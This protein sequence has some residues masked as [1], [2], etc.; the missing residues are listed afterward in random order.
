V[1]HQG[2]EWIRTSLDFLRRK[3]ITLDERGLMTA[4]DYADLSRRRAAAWY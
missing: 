1:A 2:G 4:N 3:G